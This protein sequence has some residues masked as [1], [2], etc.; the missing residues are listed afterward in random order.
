MK[1]GDKQNQERD[2]NIV[3]DYRI[4]FRDLRVTNSIIR[5][6]LLS[7]VEEV[8]STGPILM[9][10]RVVEFEDQMAQYC[11]RR[12]AVG[13]SSGT[14]ALYLALRACGVGPGDEVLTTPMSWLATLNAIVMSGATP[15]FVDVQE[16]Q[17]I[18][19]SKLVDAITQ[20]TRAIVPVHFT[21]RLCDMATIAE[22][23][24]VSNL[25]VIEDAAQ[26]MG[27]ECPEYRA[28]SIG[29]AGAFSLNPMK[30]FPGFGEAGA[31]VTDNPEVEAKL[32]SL[33]YLGT[34]NKEVCVDISLNHKMDEIQA[35]LLLD[36]FDLI[37]NLVEAR[38]TM[39]RRY[40]EKLR[41]IVGCPP[42]PP[43]GD[44]AS[45]FFDYVIF[46]KDRE[47]LRNYL[48][49]QGIETKIKHPVL[50]CDH[51]A[52]PCNPRPQIPVADRLVREMISLPLHEKMDTTDIDYVCDSIYQYFHGE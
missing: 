35:A 30:V 7:R 3:D 8:L 43:V 51:P 38:V 39:A 2:Q 47:G 15:V 18:N 42:V 22:I 5:R 27:A 25:L 32:R 24:R 1:R 4:C 28:G 26:A 10:P 34:E 16:D 49:A 13:V 48:Y 33:R 29:D 23:A 41:E 40:S 21:G 19:P 14:C 45:N 31:V 46:V 9:G 20:R 12:S 36:G 6:E 50:L 11:G 44:C 52:Y 17:N 37:G